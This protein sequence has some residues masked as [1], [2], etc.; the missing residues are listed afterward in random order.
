MTIHWKKIYNDILLNIVSVMLP[1]L[2]L[3]LISFPLIEQRFGASSFGEALFLISVFTLISFPIGNVINNVKLLT[4]RKYEEQNIQGD[5]GLIIAVFIGFAVM[6]YFMFSNAFQ[7]ETNHLYLIAI[8]ILSILKEYFIVAFRIELN[9]TAILMNNL[10]L[11]LGY[12]I[13]TY[14]FY[15][16]G[17]WELIYILGL[18][19]SLLYIYSK[20]GFRYESYNRTKNFKST[21]KDVTLLYFSVIIKNI[22]SHA[23]R[24]LMLPILGPANV[25]IYY[26]S[27]ILGKV[28]STVV[29]PISTVILSYLVKEDK[30]KKKKLI[31]QFITVA[32]LSILFYFLIVNITPIFLKFFYHDLYDSAI[33]LIPITTAIAIVNTLSSLMHPYNLRFNKLHFQMLINVIYVIFYFVTVLIL[34]RKY[35]LMGFAI[36]V[37]ISAV[38]NLFLQVIIYLRY[39]SKE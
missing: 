29:N 2:I 25:A 6:I 34:T 9:Y 23:D 17:N 13:G 31:S 27:S 36:G 11:A 14:L 21:F 37:L 28:G 26:T 16:W 19:A 3:Q 32:L 5:F 4:H 12:L 39:S 18:V 24:I 1:I 10:F 22:L 7:V 30:N 35:L 38:F 8:I 33:V 15:V 20:I